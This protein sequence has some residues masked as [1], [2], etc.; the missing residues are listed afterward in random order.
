MLI[1][2]ATSYMINVINRFISAIFASLI[3][4]IVVLNAIG[5]LVYFI[6]QLNI[7][8]SSFIHDFGAISETQR[9]DLIKSIA[10]IDE[11][12]VNNG[13]TSIE[14]NGSSSVTS[15]E[16]EE[17]MNNNAFINTFNK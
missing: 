6:K 13:L 15:A 1:S 17:Y 10:I 9:V 4:L 8:I 2:A 12:N 5:L 3:V 11:N 7:V 16:S 14:L